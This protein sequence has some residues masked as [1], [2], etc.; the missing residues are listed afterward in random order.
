MR[1]KSKEETLYVAHIVYTLLDQVWRLVLEQF[2]G[3][4][5]DTRLL[6]SDQER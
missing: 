4:E 1:G 5:V 6:Q 2:V 3:G